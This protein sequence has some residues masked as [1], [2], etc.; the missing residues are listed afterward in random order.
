[1]F[2]RA[3]PAFSATAGPAAYE[4]HQG[5]VVPMI[6]QVGFRVGMN[7]SDY[8]KLEEHKLGDTTFTI[9][10]MAP[11][12]RTECRANDFRAKCDVP[13]RRHLF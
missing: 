6:G 9:F 13:A 2:T 8:W 5:L 4:P 1:M 7:L 10:L 3:T 11:L 12:T